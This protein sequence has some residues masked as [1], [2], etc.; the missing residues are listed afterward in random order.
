MEVAVLFVVSGF[1]LFRWCSV[2]SCCGHQCVSVTDGRSRPS[3]KRVF[4]VPANQ[5]RQRS[6]AARVLLRSNDT[7]AHANAQRKR[8]RLQCAL[9][10]SARVKLRARRSGNAPRPTIA[11]IVFCGHAGAVLCRGRRSCAR[12]S[13]DPRRV[14]GRG[15]AAVT[16]C[17]MSAAAARCGG[18]RGVNPSRRFLART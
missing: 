6:P 11:S 10:V 3:P 7:M 8:S 18:E 17:V 4:V 14:E 13:G 12:S 2:V 5:V 15:T 1:C 9:R 16:R